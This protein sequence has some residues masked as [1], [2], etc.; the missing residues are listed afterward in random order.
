MS[1]PLGAMNVSSSRSMY[2]RRR[3]GGTYTISVRRIRSVL[4]DSNKARCRRKY[5][6]TTLEGVVLPALPVCQRCRF[7]M[8][9]YPD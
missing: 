5:D 6:P 7:H 9:V 8:R 4:A 3:V 2:S 1:R